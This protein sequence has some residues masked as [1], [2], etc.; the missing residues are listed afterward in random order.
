MQQAQLSGWLERRLGVPLVGQAAV[1]GGCIHQAWAL[2]LADGRRLFAKTNRLSEL[3][4]LRAEADGLA[5]LAAGAGDLVIPQPLACEAL[6]DQ[7]LLLL[8]WLP[9]AGAA[10]GG[11]GGSGSSPGAVAVASLPRSLGPVAAV[12]ANPATSRNPDPADPVTP[13]QAWGRFGAA[14]ADLH[15]RSLASSDGRFGWPQDNFIGSGPQA[16]GWLADWGQFFA[17]RRLAP[18]LALA[19][20]AGQ[21]LRQ[22]EALL[23][24]LPAWLNHHGA[25]PCL[26]HGDLWAGNGGL[27]VDG[28]GAIFD[29]AVYRGDREVDLAMARLF[30]GFP[31]SVF[32]GYETRWPLP[33]GHG[34]RR[35]IY[36]LY[37]LLNHANLFGGGYWRQAQASIDALLAA[38]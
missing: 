32:A 3:P 2:D 22:G 27:L 11:G 17:D 1:G 6:G 28:R 24:Q 33:P 34:Q 38:C 8:E 16:N 36:N 31:A 30:G 4:L 23:R 7:A 26:L 9:L 37:H 5:A 10:D 20:Q 12:P 35:E 25:E 13:A 21:P 29:P 15:R 19:A 18:Q 14:L